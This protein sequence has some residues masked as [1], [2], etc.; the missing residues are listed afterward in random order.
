MPAYKTER[1]RLP[2]TLTRPPGGRRP[3]TEARA[4]HP[5]SHVRV[6]KEP[7]RR[8]PRRRPRQ[9]DLHLMPRHEVSPQHSSQ[10]REVGPPRRREGSQRGRPHRERAAL[11][12]AHY[13]CNPS[14][15]EA[16]KAHRGDVVV[17]LHDSRRCMV[18]TTIGLPRTPQQSNRGRRRTNW[19]RA[20][21]AG[22]ETQLRHRALL[23]H[24][25][26]RTPSQRGAV[27]RT[28]D[29]GGD[30][31]DD[32]EP[33]R[34]VPHSCAASPTRV[35]SVPAR[36]RCRLLRKSHLQMRRGSAAL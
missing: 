5:P 14:S 29:R 27:L 9:P 32:R 25:A 10:T 16:N 33:G 3:L 21:P 24:G 34:Q 26:H 36:V 31:R 20:R 8:P 15:P 19:A 11:Y 12:S 2:P 28:F 7:R 22:G 4:P 35:G 18:D 23:R 13:R 17:Q 30:G 1:R 6:R